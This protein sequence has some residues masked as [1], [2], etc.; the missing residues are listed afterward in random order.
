VSRIRAAVVAL[1]VFVAPA[2]ADWVSTFDGIAREPGQERTA[3]DF[4]TR[5][6]LETRKT[7]PWHAAMARA[8]RAVEDQR[9]TSRSIMV[10]EVFL[11]PEP[12][13][14]LTDA[15]KWI[16]E[17]GLEHHRL[18]RAAMAR[19]DEKT[20]AREYLTAVRCDHAVLG[21]DDRH[22]RDVSYSAIDQ[23]VRAHAED[24]EYWGHKAFYSY[25]F[26]HATDAK[27]ALQKALQLSQD[28]YMRWIYEEGLKVC[29][30]ESAAKASPSPAPAKADPVAQS[31]R[32]ARHEQSR[33][34]LARV[35]RLLGELAPAK[36]VREPAATRSSARETVGNLKRLKEYVE[37]D[38]KSVLY[39][40]PAIGVS[41]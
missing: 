24:A 37:S 8:A 26:G 3:F 40:A 32:Q 27:L 29:A 11:R 15:K 23:L 21:F 33:E 7:A 38:L 2:R 16:A 25:Y 39:R 36:T 6:P 4:L 5:L 17:R 22:L 10:L 35:Q 28:P 34:E 18:A 19:G 31:Y 20:A 41:Y 9:W 30:R 13:P 14:D 1:M 12:M